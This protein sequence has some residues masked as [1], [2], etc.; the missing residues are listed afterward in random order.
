MGKIATS[1]MT[2]SSTAVKP[3]KQTTPITMPV[4]SE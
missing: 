3:R 2:A 4:A 1:G